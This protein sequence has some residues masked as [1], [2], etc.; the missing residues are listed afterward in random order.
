M[1][2]RLA[3]H[4]A[5][6]I[7]V[8]TARPPEVAVRMARATPP[9]VPGLGRSR[10]AA[11]RTVG[12][13]GLV[14]LIVAALRVDHRPAAPIRRSD[15]RGSSWWIRQR[16]QAVE[17]AGAGRRQIYAG[18]CGEEPTRPPHYR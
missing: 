3:Q 9:D 7:E 10:Y 14:V 11:L 6:D 15:R 12:G 1:P 8:Y 5:R 13:V 16:G 2:Q 17:K 4:I 18:P